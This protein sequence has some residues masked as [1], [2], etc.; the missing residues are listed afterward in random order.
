M[1]P[2]ID[3]H[4]YLSRWPFRRLP[5]DETPR[6]V[7][8][9]RASHVEKAW[10]GSFDALLHQDMAGVNLRLAAECRE[11]GD[12]LLVPFGC[13]NPA[14]PDWE[15]DLRR[16]HEV[17][18]MPGVRLHPNYHGYTLKDPRFVRLLQLASARGLVVQLALAMEDERVQHPLVRI[19]QVDLSPLAEM[20]K[21][22]SA[23]RL[24]VLNAPAT[25]PAGSMENLV[26]S[27]QVFFDIAMWEG[28]GGI[29]KLLRR[30]PVE[31]IVFGSHFPLYYFESAAQKLQEAALDE[32][33][34]QALCFHNASQLIV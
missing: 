20:V 6:L 1:Q 34:I 22:L 11:H 32:N 10:A 13:I 23:L 16:C 21:P 3:T 9:L 12:G 25:L 4:V 33:A 2:I 24:V 15:E 7:A 31:R 19:P 28:M 8:K 18:C 30:V 5:H 17:L 29:E 27:G 26:S 14:L